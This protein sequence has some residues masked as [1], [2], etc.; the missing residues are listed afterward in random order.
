[1]E[2]VGLESLF[3]DIIFPKSKPFV[4]G[5]CY[6]PPNDNNFIDKLRSAIELITPGTELFLLGDFNYCFTR[7]DGIVKCYKSMISSFS[8]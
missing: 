1:M 7:N 3:L 8:L 5:V 2:K 6:R 4:V